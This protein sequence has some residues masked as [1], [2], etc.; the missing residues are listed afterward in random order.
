MYLLDHSLMER[1]LVWCVT[2]A[3]TLFPCHCR[4]ATPPPKKRNKQ[5]QGGLEG[6]LSDPGDK[7]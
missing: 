4:Y 2:A 5:K 6:S 7:L 1:L 3:I